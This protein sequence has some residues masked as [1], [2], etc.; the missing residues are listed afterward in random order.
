MSAILEVKDLCKKYSNELVLN[1]INLKIYPGEILGIIGEN[2][3]GKSTL[4]QCM[5]GLVKPSKG[6]IYIKD[7][8]IKEDE[9]AAKKSLSYIP[10][11]P[12]L[13]S[14]LTVWEHL[15]LVAMAFE[16]DENDFKKKGKAL[17]QQFELYEKRNMIPSNFSKGMKQKV[18]ISCAL[19]HDADI[20]L[21]DEPFTGLD[22]SSVRDLK[23]MLID[24]NKEGK[25]I[26]I[27]T[28]ILDAAE[29][30]CQRFLILKKGESLAQGTIETIK[31]KVEIK[32]D[33]SLEELYFVLVEG[34]EQHNE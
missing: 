10:E 33:I 34:R 30:M 8:S 9:I 20:L 31:N 3:A 14:D 12:L 6:E 4:I 7:I 5:L 13:Y 19:L 16:M 24:M 18:A 21:V 28:H 2:G 26:I 27:A 25:A 32:R 1:D 11:L 17:L 29:K 23:Q 22:V 15:R